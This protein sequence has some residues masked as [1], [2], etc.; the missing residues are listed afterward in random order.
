[1]EHFYRNTTFAHDFEAVERHAWDAKTLKKTPIID[2]PFLAMRKL[3][4]GAL[5][6]RYVIRE[7]NKTSNKLGRRLR[8]Q[9]PNLGYITPFLREVTSLEE[10]ALEI[11]CHA[12]M[13]DPD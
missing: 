8:I 13:N 11:I 1:M 6:V 5:K 12:G 10:L 7:Y 9:L 3:G 2:Y 4:L